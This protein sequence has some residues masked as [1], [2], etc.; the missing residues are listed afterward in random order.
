MKHV[1]DQIRD[2]IV[3]DIRED[4][5]D[6][7]SLSKDLISHFGISDAPPLLN[8]KFT[9]RKNNSKII[10]L[11]QLVHCFASMLRRSR[12]RETEALVSLAGLR[13]N[14]GAECGLGGSADTRGPARSV[15]RDMQHK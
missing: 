9:I 7:R 8:I 15:S 11:S 13:I 2:D 1:G 4:I 3:H 10:A 12:L 14:R 6:S 5:A